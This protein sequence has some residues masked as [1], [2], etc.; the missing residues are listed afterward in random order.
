MSNIDKS[1]LIVGIIQALY[2]IYLHVKV[3]TL[4][5]L[6]KQNK[7]HNEYLVKLCNNL[8]DIVKKRNDIIKGLR[9]NE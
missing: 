8:G 7:V 3:D 2:I 6:L 1:L 9:N 4:K 5:D